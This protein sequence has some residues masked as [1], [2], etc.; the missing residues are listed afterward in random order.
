[1]AVRSA[2]EPGPAP[3]KMPSSRREIR[4][5]MANQFS[6]AQAIWDNR[7]RL[8]EVLPELR[9]VR[10]ALEDAT[11][12]PRDFVQQQWLQLISVVFAF[13]PDLIIELGR[14]YGNSTCSLAIAAKMLRPQPCRIL[15][16][17]LA[18]SFRDVSRPYLDAHHGDAALFAPLEAL[19]CDI[20]TYDFAAD[21]A[22]AKRVF[23]F[24]DAHGYDLAMG[25]LSRLFPLLQ[26]KPHLS[27]V[28]DMADL[29]YMDQELRRYGT[30]N[31]WLRH[32]SAP[33][34]YIL[35]DVGAQFEEG[36]ALV[37]FLGR[38]RVPFRSAES[39]YFTG[40]TDSQADELTEL[41]GTDFSRF[42]FWYS[43]SLNERGE[44][45]LTFPA[46]PPAPPVVSSP[47][48]AVS[49]SPEPKDE[50]VP[51]KSGIFR[52]FRN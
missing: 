50:P 21:V 18:S 31:G 5:E 49:V 44:A 30:D 41:F 20:S 9:A 48:E 22:A 29:S 23:V 3:Q 43:F 51:K 13:K 8:R 10:T 38:N 7:E 45:P 16:L 17:C 33:P 27:I 52:F 42:G 14:G 40:L 2:F 12:G 28:H 15:S 19:N 39:S 36:I 24:W 1:M 35:G 37:D 34:K 46:P 11:G 32:R 26:D 47:P 6:V 4:T 25:I